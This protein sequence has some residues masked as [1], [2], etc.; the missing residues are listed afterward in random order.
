M[1]LLFEGLF[2]GHLKETDM[3]VILKYVIGLTYVIMSCL[4]DYEHCPTD[5]SI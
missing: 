4:L 5:N 2:E 3:K 1:E